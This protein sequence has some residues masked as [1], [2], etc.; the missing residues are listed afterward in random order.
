[1][2]CARFLTSALVVLGLPALR[3]DAQR[4]DVLSVRVDKVFAQWD[5]KDSPGCAVSV[6]RDGKVAYTRGYGMANLEH[7]VPIT[8]AHG[9][10]HRLRLEAVHRRGDAL[11]A[12]DGRI[13]LLDAG[14]V[15][16]V[17]FVKL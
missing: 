8:P 16:N 14:R 10:L 7:D 5:R 11:L 12:K 17:R 15:R 1:M 3:A 4:P 6:V 2:S 9:L 13:F